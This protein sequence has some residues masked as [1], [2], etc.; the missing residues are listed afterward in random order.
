MILGLLLIAE[1]LCELFM[2]PMLFG[3]LA[4]NTT[5]A[6]IHIALGLLGAWQGWRGGGRGFCIFIGLLLLA[7]GALWFVPQAN[8]LV[9]S[10]FNVNRAVALMNLVVGALALVVALASPKPSRA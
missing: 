6:V 8:P 1:G 10:A 2:Q 9:V 7:V 5:H 4:T 3:I